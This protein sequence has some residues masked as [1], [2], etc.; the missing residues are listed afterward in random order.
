MQD[1]HVLAMIVGQNNQSRPS[2]STNIAVLQ[3]GNPGISA[4]KNAWLHLA[5]PGLRRAPYTAT[6]SAVRS[7]V[8]PNA[9]LRG[10]H[11]GEITNQKSIANRSALASS[12]ILVGNSAQTRVCSADL[13]I[14]FT[15]SRLTT[16]SR[17]T[18]SPGVS[19]TPTGIFRIV[20][21]RNAT[22]TAFRT[23]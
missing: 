8:P 13:G 17:G 20:V 14:V 3:S 2:R 4:I 7:P 6:S 22:V 1:S 18:P 5:S 9:S 16:H 12:A 11:Y 10:P 15:T 23:A 19:F 21:V